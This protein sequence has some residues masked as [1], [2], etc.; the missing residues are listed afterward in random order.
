VCGR[1][2]F[3]KASI[4]LLVVDRQQGCGTALESIGLLFHLVALAVP[5]TPSAQKKVLGVVA[6]EAIR[7]HSPVLL[8]VLHFVRYQHSEIISRRRTIG[9][10]KQHLISIRSLP[11]ALQFAELESD[12]HKIAFS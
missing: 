7:S 4:I 5:L 9:L 11:G 1:R 8:D 6:L 2:S 3:D 10:V 12:T